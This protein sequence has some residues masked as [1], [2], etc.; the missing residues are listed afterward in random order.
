MK[1]SIHI[2]L[3][4][5][6]FSCPM[7]TQGSTHHSTHQSIHQIALE[8]HYPD[9]LPPGGILPRGVNFQSRERNLRSTIVGFLPYWVSDSAWNTLT[10][11]RISHL[12]WFSAEL[13]TNGSISTTHG[14][15][16]G[17]MVDAM[18]AQGVQVLLTATLFG[19]QSLR[20]LLGSTTH[21]ATARAALIESMQQG[22]A[23]GLMID[24][25]AL[26]SDQFWTFV[27]FMADLKADLDLLGTDLGRTFNLMVCTPAVDW[28]GSYYYLELSRLCDALFI[29]AYDYHWSGSATTGPVSP[30]AGWGTYNVPWTINDYLYYNADQPEKLILGLPW[31]GYDWPCV[32]ADAGTETTSAATA[33][34]YNSAKSL[35]STHGVLRDAIAQTPWTAYQQSGW[36]QCW[37]DDTLSLGMKMDLADDEGFQGIGMWA[38]GYEAEELWQQIES[39]YLPP[40]QLPAV[41]DLMIS[42]LG[43]NAWLHWSPQAGASTYRIYRAATPWFQ[44]SEAT[45]AAETI[46][47]SWVFPLLGGAQFYRVTVLP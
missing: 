23:D 3:F 25:E 37:Y 28:A 20:D 33:R 30:A 34:T 41:N 18:H 32:S 40:E 10:G 8:A 22:D 11:D 29:M 14:W 1:S 46:E 17:P 15:P 6:V 7:L 36:R 16:H 35:A 12:C 42:R 13:A 21:Q 9:R 43:G 39:R 5:L 24:F 45:F 47:P 31:Y 4:I 38:L 27:N 44:P 2:I 19:S 26:P